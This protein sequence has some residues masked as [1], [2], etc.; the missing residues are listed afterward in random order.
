MPHIPN[1]G[2]EV[3]H[4]GDRGGKEPGGG[5]GKFNPLP[6]EEGERVDPPYAPVPVEPG[7]FTPSGSIFGWSWLG[8]WAATNAPA[9]VVAWLE[10]WVADFNEAAQAE[11][12]GDTVG[13]QTAVIVE[14]FLV[15][16]AKQEWW[17][18]KTALWQSVQKLK[19][20]TDVPRG[21]Y[22]SLVQS[23]RD[24]IADTARQLGFVDANGNLTFDVHSAEIT[25]LIE[26]ADG[27]ML[28]AGSVVNGFPTPDEMATDRLIEQYFLPERRFD[29]TE[30]SPVIG[31]GE[32]QQHYDWIKNLAANNF[33]SLEDEEIWDMVFRL[34]REEISHQGVWD[35]I[36]GHVGDR[37]DFL[38]GTNIM[39]RI[40]QFTATEEA[41]WSGG[42]NLKTHL[43]PIRDVVAS[44]WGLNSNE[45]KLNKV[46][47]ENL[48]TL[49]IADATAP[50]GERFM[51][52]REA[53]RWA[54]DQPQ[55][56]QTEEYGTGM[57][58]M[59]QSILQ[60][61]GAR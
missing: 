27:L 45:V 2:P 46:F 47:G 11:L 1:V 60:L 10:G 32:L 7:N 51:N 59:V 41:G 34:K 5:G 25:N 53:R 16:L 15:D 29:T 31:G 23:Y 35:R 18:E 43:T 58:S 37:Y 42:S 40:N 12:E 20:G 21:E 3:G 24:V 8:E 9:E 55:F 54:R 28:N 61:F 38:E 57:Q 33:I 17:A 19:Y 56:K 36:S 4:G 14:N 26:G 6:D 52:S 13:T 48:E 44:T 39:N 50:N 49:T 30:G 22:D